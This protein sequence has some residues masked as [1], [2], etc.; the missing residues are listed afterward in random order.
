MNFGQK[1]G[2]ASPSEI[3]TVVFLCVVC[4]LVFKFI[5]LAYVSKLPVYLDCDFGFWKFLIK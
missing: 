5:S 3:S 4:V 2:Q 1:N